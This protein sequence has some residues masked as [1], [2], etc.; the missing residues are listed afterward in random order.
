MPTLTI[1]GGPAS[2]VFGNASWSLSAGV[3]ALPDFFLRQG[4]GTLTYS[5]TGTVRVAYREAVL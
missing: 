2:L 5:G 4:E 3:Y 1:E